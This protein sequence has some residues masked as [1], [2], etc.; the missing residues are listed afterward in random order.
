MRAIKT[1]FAVIMCFAIMCPLAAQTN[2]DLLLFSRVNEYR[3]ENKIEPLIW[4]SSVYKMTEHHTRY[5]LAYVDDNKY[6]ETFLND[7]SGKNVELYDYTEKQLVRTN[8]R[9]SKGEGALDLN[10]D[11]YGYRIEDIRDILIRLKFDEDL[12]NKYCNI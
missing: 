6:M 8:T 2:L 9:R 3:I 4:D 5:L 1:L 12:I 10:F 7:L 11:Y